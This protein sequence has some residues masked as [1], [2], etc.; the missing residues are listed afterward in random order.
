MTCSV[1]VRGRAD[2]LDDEDAD[3]LLPGVLTLS[4]INKELE[5]VRGMHA[6]SNSHTPLLGAPWLFASPDLDIHRVHLQRALPP[7]SSQVEH[8]L[9]WR[10][11]LSWKAFLVLGGAVLTVS[12]WCD[13]S[14][15]RTRCLCLIH[16]QVG[17]AA[18]DCD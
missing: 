13:R 12:N 18:D 7:R 1:R 8:K 16:P 17:A 6:S 15:I 14:H 11:N 5:E 9:G 2:V 3:T 10:N 4:L